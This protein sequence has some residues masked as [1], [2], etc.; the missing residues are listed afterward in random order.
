L[1]LLL[2]AAFLL[3]TLRAS[4][5]TVCVERKPEILGAVQGYA[6][7]LGN[8]ECFVDIGPAYAPNMVYRS[9]SFFDTGLL[10]VFNSYGEGTNSAT[11]G[12]REY[13]F[14]P[15]SGKPA[16]QMDAAAGTILV[17]MADGD[18]VSIDS[19]TAQIASSSRGEVAVSPRIDPANLGGVEFPHYDGLMLDTGY[20]RGGSPA[21][22]PDRQSTFR[23]PQGQLCRV[24]N[25]E[26]FAYA[27]RD[28][29]FKF[30][31]AALSAFLKKRCP[32]LRAGF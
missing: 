30:D 21:N 15:R 11:T 16:L 27:G 2:L 4:A 20:A 8:G 19:T 5:N 9:Y 29:T 28:H 32:A 18:V 22:S 1:K 25:R 31:D 24:A 7:S 17:T 13:Y 12:A 10:M 23:S 3:P 14:F 26:I 6:D